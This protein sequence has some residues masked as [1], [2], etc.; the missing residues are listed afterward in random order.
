LRSA[1]VKNVVHSPEK[2]G[3]VSWRQ[4]VV[5]VSVF[6]P[7]QAYQRHGKTQ[8]RALPFVK[9]ERVDVLYTP[10]PPPLAKR[11][12]GNPFVTIYSWKGPP[13]E[14]LTLDMGIEDITVIK[15]KEIRFE[16][17]P[18]RIGAVAPIPRK[19]KYPEPEK[20]LYQDIS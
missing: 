16:R 1:I 14:L 17:V 4:G 15:G 20:L 2:P 8:Y 10:N 18:A 13:P 6:P 12:K 3:I 19:V 11:Y 5:W 9:G 7:F